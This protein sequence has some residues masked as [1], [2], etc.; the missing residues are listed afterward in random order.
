MGALDDVSDET[1]DSFDDE[2]T[3]DDYSAEE[4]GTATKFGAQK[5]QVYRPTGSSPS[6][7]SLA[8]LLSS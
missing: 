3:D 7:V 1:G 2:S 5:A 8:S 6:R 4:A